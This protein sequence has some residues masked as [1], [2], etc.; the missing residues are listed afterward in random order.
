MLL[1]IYQLR[2][3]EN[4]IFFPG[5]ILVELVIDFPNYN[6]SNAESILILKPMGRLSFLIDM[7]QRNIRPK[8]AKRTLDLYRYQLYKLLSVT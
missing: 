5:Y 6:K 3:L 7:F 4:K 8:W 2:R 1:I